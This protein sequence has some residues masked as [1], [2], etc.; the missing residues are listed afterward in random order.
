MKKILSIIPMILVFAFCAA[1]QVGE[2]L[3]KSSVVIYNN[4]KNKKIILLGNNT[5]LDTFKLMENEVWLS[6]P[7]EYDPIFKLQTQNHVVNY[8][9]KPGNYYMIFWNGKKKYWDLKKSKK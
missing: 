6:P 1:Q 2:R 8:Q 3:T 9:L 5:K 7:F 4:T